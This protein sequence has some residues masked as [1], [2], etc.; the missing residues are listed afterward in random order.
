VNNVLVTL[1]DLKNEILQRWASVP[2]GSVSVRIID[3][4]AKLPPSN[5][6]M[7]TYRT[8]LAAAGKS[9]VDDDLLAA[10]NILVSSPI[11]V[12]DAHGLFIDDD[13]SEF[14]LTP[15]ELLETSRSGIFIHPESG[16]KVP[17]Y[18]DRIV[19]FFTPTSRFSDAD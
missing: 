19:P 1:A 4:I 11:S 6:H 14:E 18:R 13:D 12:F 3:Y 15:E 17:D 5:R 2:A 8:F 16:E 10:I 7:L 9:N